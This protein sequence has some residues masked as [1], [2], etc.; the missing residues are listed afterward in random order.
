M[1]ILIVKLSSLGDVVHALPVVADIRAAYPRAL[2]DWVVEPAF[3]PLLHR[4]VGIAEVIECPLRHWTQA[5][6]WKAAVVR[7]MRAFAARLRSERYDGVVDL[8][9]LTKSALIARLARGKSFGLAN[10]TDGASHEAPARWLVT[11]A[12]RVEPHSHALDRSRELVAAALGTRID[13]P[14]SFGLAPRAPAAGESPRTVVLIHGTSRA[15]KLWP[16]ASWIEIGRRLADEGLTV[17][18]PQADAEEGE[19]ALAIAAG[20]GAECTVWPALDLGAFI[21]RLGATGAA[22]GVDSGPS[23]I[24]VALGLP[25]VQLYNFATSWRTGPQPRHGA[26]LQVS[27][28]GDPVPTVAVVWAAWK[29]VQ[30]VAR[31]AAAHA[32]AKPP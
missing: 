5:G 13:S 30:S 16:E 17:A 12:I 23:H 26:G 11:K 31:V 22:I 15:D 3:A 27:V 32:A 14:P 7:E 24:A 10:R 18:L 8:Q 28:E 9:G 1:R 29:G 4:T 2:I 6:L 25:H 20:I 19:R 21:D